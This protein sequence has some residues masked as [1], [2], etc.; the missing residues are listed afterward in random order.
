MGFRLRGLG[1][2][3]RFRIAAFGFRV[4]GLWF[5]FFF[6]Y[7]RGFKVYPTAHLQGCCVGLS[8]EVAFCVHAAHKHVP[9]CQT[10]CCILHFF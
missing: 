8:K 5:L 7:M 3:F 9:V 2:R 4:Q 10:M 6:F 1:L